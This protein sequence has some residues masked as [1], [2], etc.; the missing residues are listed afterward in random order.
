M[1]QRDRERERERERE[2][3]EEK[4]GLVIMRLLRLDLD[5]ESF[6]LLGLVKPLARTLVPKII[7]GENNT[8]QPR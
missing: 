5:Q 6:D 4:M 8:P 1:I 2:R 3:K 7:F